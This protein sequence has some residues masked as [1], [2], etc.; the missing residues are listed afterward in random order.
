MVEDDRPRWEAIA[1]KAQEYREA[2]LA[3]IQP[4]VQG[5]PTLLPRNV[6]EALRSKLSS[7]EIE[8]TELPLESLLKQL[9]DGRLSAVIVTKAF[10]RR[11]AL[12]QRFVGLLYFF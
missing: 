6:F 7:Q 12:A 8:I 4:H 3:K 1:Q 5:I 10:L 9:H 11:A 2:T